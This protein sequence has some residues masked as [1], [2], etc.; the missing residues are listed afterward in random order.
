MQRSHRRAQTSGQIPTKGYLGRIVVRFLGSML[1]SLVLASS[2]FG[3]DVGSQEKEFLGNGSVI[4]VTVHCASGEPFSAPALVKLFRG[5][6]PSGQ[7]DTSRGVAEFVVIG[8]GEFSVVVS[9]PGYTEAQ[10]DVSVDTTGRARVDVYLRPTSVAGSRTAVPGRPL[11]APRAKEALD[12]GLRA[13]RENKLGE[14]E[15]YMGEAMRLA[16]ANPDVLYA[17][18]ILYLKRGDWGQAQTVLE[19]A[20]QIDPNSAPGLCGTWVGTLRPGRL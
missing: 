8:L 14:A 16:P 15:K 12:K 3:Q 17:Q 5:I 10:R 18:G 4:T 11:L 7:R 13:L 9:A 6:V 2:L 1:P 19:K 20:T